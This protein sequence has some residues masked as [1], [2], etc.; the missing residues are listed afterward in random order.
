MCAPLLRPTGWA[1]PGAVQTGSPSL[2]ALL[3][4]PALCLSMRAA[5]MAG[6]TTGLSKTYK[7]SKTGRVSGAKAGTK[8]KASAAP[9]RTVAKASASQAAP[10]AIGPCRGWPPAATGSLPELGQWLCRA[11]SRGDG[12]GAQG[13]RPDLQVWAVHRHDAPGAVCPALLPR[14]SGRLGMLEHGAGHVCFCCACVALDAGCSPCQGQ[15][16]L[17]EQ[18]CSGMP[19]SIS[20]PDMQGCRAL[21]CL[22]PLRSGPGMCRWERS[23]RFGLDPPL[24]VKQ[25]LEGAPDSANQNVWAGRT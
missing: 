22:Y 6:P 17:P 8:D 10:G 11:V 7:Q 13:V 2:S 15:G 5:K 4:V 19:R 23:Q 25:L 3:C 14:W 24:Q 9:Q 21:R 20:G 16:K 12:A 18:L 1:A